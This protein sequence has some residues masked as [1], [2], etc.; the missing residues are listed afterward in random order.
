MGF[1]LF[2][3]LLAASLLLGRIFR[4]RIPVIKVKPSQ[5]DIP[6]STEDAFIPVVFGTARVTPKIATHGRVRNKRKKKDGQTVG[7]IYGGDFQLVLCHGP[8]NSIEEVYLDNKAL[9]TFPYKF[10]DSE[11]FGVHQDDAIGTQVLYPT[12]PWVNNTTGFK[13]NGDVTVSTTAGNKNVTASAAIFASTD[14]NKVLLIPGAGPQGADYLGVITKFTSTTIVECDDLIRYKKQVSTRPATTV[15]AVPFWFI[16][17]PLQN[18]ATICSPDLFGGADSDGGIEASLEVMFGSASQTQ[19][20]GLANIPTTG[21]VLNV[22]AYDKIAYVMFYAWNLGHSPYFRPLQFVVKRIPDVLGNTTNANIGS[23]AN[24]ADIIYETMTNT[25]WG[26]GIPT[27]SLSLASFQTAQA[28]LKAEGFGVSFIIDNEVRGEEFIDEVL[29]HVDGLV[30]PNPTTGLIEMKLMRDDFTVGSLPILDETNCESIRFTRGTFSPTI[31][32]VRVTFT[33][34]ANDYK[35]SQVMAD[36]LANFQVTGDARA[37]TYDFNGIM[38]RA[39]AQKTAARILRSVAVPLGQATIRTNRKGFNLAVGT[40]F[41]MTYTPAGIS[42]VVMRVSSINYG[43]VEEG[44]IEIEAVEDAFS[45]ANAIYTDPTASS[46][47]PSSVVDIDHLVESGNSV[48]VQARGAKGDVKQIVGTISAAGVTLTVAGGGMLATD[49]GKIIHI[50]DAGPNTTG[51][52]DLLTTIASYSS[53]TSVNVTTA[54]TR[55]VTSG[56]VIYGTDDTPAF[57]AAIDAAATLGQIV[58]VPDVLYPS[59]GYGIFQLQARESVR[60]E[61]ASWNSVLYSL[62]GRRMIQWGVSK[63][64]NRG[65]EA[66]I[67][68][69]TANGGATLTQD[70]V[71]FFAGTKSLKVVTGASANA[72]AFCNAASSPVIGGCG[73]CVTAMIHGTGAVGKVIQ[74]SLEWRNSAG[75]IISISTNLITLVS[76]WAEYKLSAQSPELARSCYATFYQLTAGTVTFYLDEV[77]VIPG[78]DAF[79]TMASLYPQGGVKNI[80]FD[81]GLRHHTSYGTFVANANGLDDPMEAIAVLGPS[82][83]TTEFSV[84]SCLFSDMRGAPANFQNCFMVWDQLGNVVTGCGNSNRPILI[85]V[86]PTPLTL[87][88]LA[89]AFNQGDLQVSWTANVDVLHKQYEVREGA[90]WAAGTVLRIGNFSG[91]SILKQGITKRSYTIRVRAED[92]NGRQGTEATITATQVAPDAS[93]LVGGDIVGSSLTGQV[94]LVIDATATHASQ[95]YLY[96][97]ITN[98]FTPSAANRVAEVNGRL[99]PTG[100]TM[101]FSLPS[102]M[103]GAVVYMKIGLKDELTDILGE[104]EVYSG[105]VS[106]TGNRVN[107]DDIADGITYKRTTYDEVAST[108][109][110][111]ANMIPNGNFEG[112]IINGFGALSSSFALVTDTANP[113]GAQVMEI[114]GASKALIPDDPI[115]VDPTQAYVISIRGKAITGT[116]AAY[117]AVDCLDSAKVSILA[118]EVFAPG[119]VMTTL[120]NNEAIG[121][122]AIE[123]VSAAG[124]PSSYTGI[125]W[126]AFN[127]QTDYSDLP[128]R[129]LYKILSKVGNT[130]NLDTTQHPTGLTEAFSSGSNVRY[131]KDASSYLYVDSTLAGDPI[132]TTAYGDFYGVVNNVETNHSSP[133]AN[134]FRPGTRYVL[135]RVSANW[136]GVG[137]DVSRWDDFR[138]QKIEDF[139]W[140]K[141]ANTTLSVDSIGQSIGLLVDDI[142]TN[143]GGQ[144][145]PVDAGLYTVQATGWTL[146]AGNALVASKESFRIGDRCLMTNNPSA[147]TSESYQDLPLALGDTVI[148]SAWVKATG[149]TATA[150]KYFGLKIVRQSGLVLTVKETNNSDYNLAGEAHIGIEATNATVTAWQQ[151]IVA[152]TVTT[153]GTMRLTASTSIAGT[154]NGKVFW[155]GITAVIVPAGLYSLFQANGQLA[156]SVSI[157]DGSGPRTLAKGKQTGLS[158][159]GTAVTFSPWT[160]AQIP[161]VTLSG[162]VTYEGRSK[163]GTIAQVDAQSGNT[164][165][166]AAL[167]QYEQFT[168]LSKTVSGFTTRALLV[169][170][171]GT[172]TARSVDFASGSI[173][174]AVGSGGAASVNLGATNLPAADS[175][176]TVGFRVHA[177]GLPKY[178]VGTITIVV[179]VDSDDSGTGSNW[180]QRDTYTWSDSFDLGVT[181]TYDDDITVTISD[182]TLGTSDQVRVRVVSV[183]TTL[184]ISSSWNVKPYGA[185]GVP[186]PGVAW[187]TTTD[188][189]ASKTPDSTNE[190]T[191]V[192]DGYF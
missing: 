51:N 123:L 101:N 25:D 188:Q 111:G 53:P 130:I 50:K 104:A 180:Q 133:S 71:T 15:A 116:P 27:S 95:L 93:A 66:G 35:D 112:P 162:G 85:N 153:A 80:K 49:V 30:Y 127:C 185:T 155:D 12:V 96:A 1:W 172:P 56:T 20:K 146:S 124:F 100:V 13:Q 169:Q 163:W 52:E 120:V 91:I 83:G 164:T 167:P 192:A 173:I 39:T 138:F 31:N 128:N 159:N 94:K 73:Y 74:M 187:I 148:V 179:A 174:T 19:S 82:G 6:T 160:F 22:S 26:L 131:H 191:W 119:L 79:N 41:K 18:A 38:D 92:V 76:G 118:R 88:G 60:I 62:S 97:S 5:F 122:T 44:T 183:V 186:T 29:R 9:S 40:P 98:G 157:Y 117:L 59:I 36:D 67:T 182:A 139:L 17:N 63:N 16:Y 113:L 78:H 37:E 114:T 65:F 32:R 177:S 4:P 57:Q 102:T 70:A 125:E 107:M 143:G 136:A 81:G 126:I 58:E 24:A 28:T 132:P 69:W 42:N 151:I 165:A 189:Y 147:T 106:L 33:S 168:A 158:K 141:G 108:Y 145:G 170:K 61:G 99:D 77:Y 150:G 87:A 140:Q 64:L 48:N 10:H 3:G 154:N 190:I 137:T 11:Y 34:R 115:P 142:V 171:T 68:E 43:S 129:K 134:R 121:Q 72:G 181:T 54:A 166:V 176:Y 175:N 90:S 135:P 21:G 110:L 86:T 7:F 75:G 152:F 103:L 2:V 161:V 23:D 184:F 178:T 89:A 156:N 8:I 149:M 45:T 144:T 105:Q 84:E 109:K 46:W 14:V 47:T 55:A